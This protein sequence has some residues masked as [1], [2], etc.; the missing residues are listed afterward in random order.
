MAIAAIDTSQD[1]EDE[2]AIIRL[3]LRRMAA[4]MTD[5]TSNREMVAIAGILLDGASRIA[6]LLK[7]QRALSGDAADGISGAIAKALQ[8][9][10]TE[11]GIDL[12]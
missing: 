12:V 9:L 2:I 5:D 8:E 6:G 4:R 3:T 1:L 11:W 7:V 10:G